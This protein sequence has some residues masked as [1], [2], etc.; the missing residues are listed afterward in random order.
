MDRPRARR[1]RARRP[2]RARLGL[3]AAVPALGLCAVAA[4]A[5]GRD[6]GAPR[7]HAAAAGEVGS[8]EEL[9]PAARRGKRIYQRGATEDGRPIEGAIVGGAAALSGREAACA[10]CHGP[11]GQG[12]TEGGVTAPPLAAE[13]RL[14]SSGERGGG[15]GQGR[16]PG[17]GAM[18]AAALVTAIREGRGPAGPWLSPVMPRY[19][20]EEADLSDLVEYLGC[21][22]RDLDPGITAG[23]V[24]LGAALPLTGPDA[25]VGAAARDVL[26]AAFA[27]VNAQG[28]IYRRRLELRVEDSAGPSGEAGA[29]ARLLDRGVLALVGSAFDGDPA[30]RARLSEERAPLVGPLA[31]AGAPGLP[32]GVPAASAPGLADGAPGRAREAAGG[33]AAGANDVVF[34]VLP[35]PDV[36]ARVAIKHLAGAPANAGSLALV[37]H[38]RDRAGEAWASGARAEAAHRDLPAPP[39]LSFEPGRLSPRDVAG[40]VRAHGARAVLFWGPGAD[41]A[42]ARAAL[43]DAGSAAPIYASLGSIAGSAGAPSREIAGRVLFLYPGSL[44]ERERASEDALQ[45]FLRRAGVAPGP[46]GVQAS[47]Y[48]AAQIAIEALKRAGAHATREGLIAA[49]EQLRDF[50]AGPAP[51]VTFA[52]NRRTGVLGASVFRMDPASDAAVRA[53]VWIEVVP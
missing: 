38:T 52:R 47:A 9:S 4:W 5:L 45:A 6:E 15:A 36:L 32:G 39:A 42:S 13:R 49:L 26:I 51:P 41:L 28:G 10:G 37:V 29:T 40:A 25:P 18:S 14:A 17:E 53:S 46:L 3:L 12:T 23:S 27:D 2:G 1:P 31:L 43:D 24:A 19:R 48:V 50:D 20:L 7:A 30:L 34:Q 16:R 11:S 44:G 33:G 35:G 21:V 22:G 8:C